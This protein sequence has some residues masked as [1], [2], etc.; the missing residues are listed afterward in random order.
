MDQQSK[1]GFTY[2]VPAIG[3]VVVHDR[4]ILLVQR[5]KPPYLGLWTLPGGK[6]RWGETMLAAA[7]REIWEETGLIVK[8]EC[9][10][11]AIEIMDEAHAAPTFHYI[12]IDIRAR[13]L[14]G[15][16]VARDDALAVGWFSEREW[17]ELQLDVKTKAL[18]VR[19]ASKSELL[20][21]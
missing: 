14:G 18:L 4:R 21:D 2:P 1:I 7:E 5:R 16:I 19:L 8:A 12:V 3:V 20:L 13:Y 9:T 17:R 11:D 15:E 6:I 10:L